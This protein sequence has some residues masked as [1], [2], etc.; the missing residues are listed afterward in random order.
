MAVRLPGRGQLLG[1]EMEGHRPRGQGPFQLIAERPQ[2]FDRG[3][4]LVQAGGDHH[5]VQEVADHLRGRWMGTARGGCGEGDRAALGVTL[6]QQPEG[7]RVSDE[8][9]GAGGRR[10]APDGPAHGTF[11]SPGPQ[12]ATRLASPAGR[13]L[14]RQLETLRQRVEAATPFVDLPA[15]G[16]RAAPRRPVDPVVV[17]DLRLARCRP[18]Q[19]DV[20]QIAPDNA[21]RALVG[22]DVVQHEKQQALRAVGPHDQAH[23]HQ[24]T[25]LQV[26][27]PARPG[28]RRL[29]LAPLRRRQ[30]LERRLGPRGHELQHR[31]ALQPEGRAQD[32]V[33]G[34]HD[35]QRPPQRLRVQRPGH[36]EGAAQV[37]GRG[38]G[39]D[40]VEQPQTVLQLA[41][42]RRRFHSRCTPPDMRSFIR[43]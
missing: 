24:G 36:S 13:G 22:Q 33:P 42:A 21:Q 26:E 8:R 11:Q 4:L 1:Q 38:G 10:Q 7:A 6:E 17:L 2:R 25:G 29:V 40:A 37:V 15:P 19:V 16:G 20:G 34:D 18:A 39:I 3:Q 32:A 30:H 23:A 28:D 5:R 43:S 14:E 35:P 41:Q 27:R 31:L 12:P 9:A